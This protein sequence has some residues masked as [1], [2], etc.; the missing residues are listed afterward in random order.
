MLSACSQLKDSVCTVFRTGSKLQS[1]C[2]CPSF[3]KRLL[4]WVLPATSEQASKLTTAQWSNVITSRWS[5][6]KHGILLI[7]KIICWLLFRL[8][9]CIIGCVRVMLFL[10]HSGLLSYRRLLPAGLDLVCPQMPPAA[11]PWM[12]NTLHSTVIGFFSLSMHSYSW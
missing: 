8:N 7:L 5:Q 6:C 1:I 9:A 2:L 10:S 12:R 4:Q 11:A 3:S